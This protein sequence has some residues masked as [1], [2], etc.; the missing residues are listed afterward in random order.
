MCLAGLKASNFEL[1]FFLCRLQ[2]WCSHLPLGAAKGETE[3]GATMDRAVFIQR[4]AAVSVATAAGLASCG[5]QPSLATD[6]LGTLYR[7][8]H[9]LKNLTCTTGVGIFVDG[10]KYLV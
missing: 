2:R 3:G 7:E 1:I 5:L 6:V 10:V 9:T 8:K 4:T